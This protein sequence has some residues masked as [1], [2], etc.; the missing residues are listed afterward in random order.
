MFVALIVS[1]SCKKKD[2]SH[3][4]PG[5]Q[6]AGNRL[7][8]IVSDSVEGFTNSISRRYTIAP[9]TITLRRFIPTSIPFTSWITMVWTLI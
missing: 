5:H 7:M 8:I 6:S 9:H 3:G 4:T 2:L 1:A